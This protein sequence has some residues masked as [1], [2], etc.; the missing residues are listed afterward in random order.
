MIERTQPT[1]EPRVVPLG[2]VLGVREGQSSRVDMPALLAFIRETVTRLDC[3]DAVERCY[4]PK[5]QPGQTDERAYNSTTEKWEF[6]DEVYAERVQTV[7]CAWNEVPVMKRKPIIRDKVDADGN[8]VIDPK[9]NEP[10]QEI[11]AW[12]IK[13]S[14]RLK[15]WT[16]QADVLVG[17]FREL[18]QWNTPQGRGVICRILESLYGNRPVKSKDLDDPTRRGRIRRERSERLK[19]GAR[20]HRQRMAMAK[21]NDAV[22][23]LI[24]D[25]FGED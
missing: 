3:A 12:G 24:T 17:A 2:A 18:A 19:A 4:R 13:L 16:E 25:L 7:L 8:L 15:T 20:A 1:V 11:V 22:E 23:S 14:K 5:P 9:T 21:D 10:V 6:I